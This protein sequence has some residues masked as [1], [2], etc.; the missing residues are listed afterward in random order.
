MGSSDSLETCVSGVRQDAFPDRPA[1]GRVGVSRVS[2]F[3]CM[4]FSRV[5]RV[6]DSAASRGGLRLASPL[7]LPSPY[8]YKVG[9]PKW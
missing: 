1:P 3:P 4:E 2:R 8:K 5:R 7:M 6:F 9:T